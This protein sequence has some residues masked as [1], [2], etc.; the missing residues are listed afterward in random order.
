MADTNENATPPSGAMPMPHGSE[1]AAD[2]PPEDGAL[3]MP[4]GHDEEFPEWLR[5]RDTVD[6]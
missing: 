1:S 2:L 6:E 5:T 4:H 3:P